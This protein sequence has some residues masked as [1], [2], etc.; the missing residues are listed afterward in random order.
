MSE[1]AV[2]CECRACLQE[3]D[4]HIMIGRLKVPA[5]MTRM[6]LCE[7]CGSKRCPHANDHRHAC[8]GS[9]EPGQAGSAYA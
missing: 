1:V 9:N 6:V 3:R 4:E 2:A 8:T 7:T 5:E